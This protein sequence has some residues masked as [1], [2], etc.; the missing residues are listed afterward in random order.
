MNRNN[1]FVILR[2]ALS[3]IIGWN[4]HKRFSWYLTKRRV[5]RALD[6]DMVGLLDMPGVQDVF[7]E[8]AVDFIH[9]REGRIKIVTSCKVT[10]TRNDSIIGGL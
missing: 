3:P 8:M 1:L 5:K 6:Q 9:G 4:W 10:F 7:E 2:R